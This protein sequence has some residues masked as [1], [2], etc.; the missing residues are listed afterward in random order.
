MQCIDISRN[1]SK[2]CGSHVTFNHVT[3]RKFKQGRIKKTIQQ[4]QQLAVIFILQNMR[5]KQGT[6]RIIWQTFTRSYLLGKE[7]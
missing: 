5:S 4:K 2:L 6:E 3:L 7:K 1:V